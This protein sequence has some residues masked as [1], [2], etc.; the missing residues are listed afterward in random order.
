MIKH[1]DLY[2]ILDDV[3]DYK[4]FLTVDEL[5]DSGRQ[6]AG[7]VLFN[8]RF[9]TACRTQNGNTSSSSPPGGGSLMGAP[10]FPSRLPKNFTVRAVIS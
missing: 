6:L 1:Q 5:K 8:C 4:T 3:P 7:G 9:A 2:G 10:P